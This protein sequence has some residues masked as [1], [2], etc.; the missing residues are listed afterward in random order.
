ME[1]NVKFRYYDLSI[2]E[3]E[4]IYIYLSKAFN[5][6]EERLSLDEIEK[7]YS[8]I[9]END[10]S[11]TFIELIFS[12]KFESLFKILTPER[13]DSIKNII[14]EI[15]HRRG[16][17]SVLVLFKF[18]GVININFDIVFYILNKSD[19]PFEMA[20]EKIEYLVDI[21]PTQLGN[22]P[23]DI[24]EVVYHFDDL[25]AK[26]IPFHARKNDKN[27]HCKFVLR[28]GKWEIIN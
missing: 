12:G 8:N 18:A 28:D 17:R 25:S 11:L 1:S 20:I 6:T 16:K 13:W 19:K 23:D 22:L 21:V 2:R 3:I 24:I 27:Y 5:V 4:L 26:W 7:E 15:K 14:K 10:R 9:F